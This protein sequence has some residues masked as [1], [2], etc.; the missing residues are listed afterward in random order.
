MRTNVPG[1]DSSRTLRSVAASSPSSGG[2]AHVRSFRYRPAALPCGGHRYVGHRC[3]LWPVR[4]RPLDTVSWRSHL[5]VPGLVYT[6]YHHPRRLP[7][8]WYRLGARPE[9]LTSAHHAAALNGGGLSSG[10]RPAKQAP[11]GPSRP[12]QEVFDAGA[13][14]HVPAQGRG[15]RSGKPGRVCRCDW[16]RWRGVGP[17]GPLGAASC[18]VSCSAVAPAGPDADAAAGCGQVMTVPVST[19]RPWLRGVLTQ[20]PSA[21]MSVSTVVISPT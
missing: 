9:H 10:R 6:Q 21:E 8:A 5:Q 13:E 1:P 18:A 19:H 15:A 12:Q 2:K 14:A 20:S 4:H 17:G 7:T 3:A 11:V 16:F